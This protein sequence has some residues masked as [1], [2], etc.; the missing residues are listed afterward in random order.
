MYDKHI[1]RSKADSS[2]K[3]NVEYGDD[4]IEEDGGEWD[5][6]VNIATFRA[7]DGGEGADG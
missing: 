1:D 6:I 4:D 3:L 7:V 2:S 5:A